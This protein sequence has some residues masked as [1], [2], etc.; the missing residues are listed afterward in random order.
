[1]EMIKVLIIDDSSV[2]RQIIKAS[3][4][5]CSQIKVVGEAENPFVARDLIKKLNPDVL[6]LDVEMPKMDGI[7]FLTNLMRLRPMPVIMLST[8]TTKGAD[9]TLQ[10]LELGA[11]DFI[12]KPS[13]EELIATRSS[14]GEVLIN[15][16]IQAAQ[17]D[18]KNFKLS[19]AIHNSADMQSSD[20]HRESSST[21]NFQEQSM[22]S[23]ILPFS[24]VKESKHIVAIGASTG[25]TDAIKKILITLPK[26][27][28]AVVIALHIP[29]TFSLR[30]AERL[31]RCCQVEVHEAMHGQKIKQGHVYIAP[32]DRHLEIVTKGDALFCTLTDTPEV[33]RHKPAVDVLFNSLE[34]NAK[35]TQ[36]ILLTGM[37]QDGAQGMLHL[38]KL[39]A[40]TI[41]QDK[42]SSLIWG[43]P[44]KAY[45]ISAH[46]QQAPLLN[47]AHEILSYASLSQLAMQ[48]T[49]AKY[50][51]EKEV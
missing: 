39:G 27:A 48:Q 31:N 51:M 25:G 43:M 26:N 1:M 44:G 22:S 28:P 38:K 8:L 17:I 18:Q 3:L 10:A 11:I 14:F 12:A 35:N 5:D 40:R 9:I 6:T 36:A 50:I 34:R 13:V 20:I 45:A 16:I 41:I 42:A 37:G 33:N 7:T 24:G 19:D 46:S 23:P 29:K 4:A 30:F 49:L 2:I 21:G 15:K 32:G 47:I